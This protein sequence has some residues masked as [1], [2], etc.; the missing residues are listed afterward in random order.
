ME[1]IKMRSIVKTYGKHETAVNALKG[2]DLSVN[3]GEL[4]AIVGPS[5]SGKTTLLNILGCLDSPDSGEYFV[6]DI[7]VESLNSNKLAKIRNL[8]FG[9]V[10]QNFALLDDYTV[11]ENIKIPLD[12]SESKIKNKKEIISN[13]LKKL[14]M[15]DK[16]NKYPTELSGGQC[17]R[18]SIARALVNDPE[19]ILADEPTGSLDKK[20]GQQV[21]DIFKSI[22]NEKKTIIIVTHDMDIA[23]QCDRIIKIED[24]NV[25]NSDYALV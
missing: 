8:K 13:I 23:S 25:E 4:I 2:I 12:Y 10:V 15:E 1:L 21:M 20:M 18:V 7:N 5:G 24:G 11:F 9:F 22:K 3:K 6:D 17:Q 16:I 14:N 19:I